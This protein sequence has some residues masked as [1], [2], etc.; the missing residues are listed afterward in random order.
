MWYTLNAKFQTKMHACNAVGCMLL[1]QNWGTKMAWP[2][3]F[4]PTYNRVRPLFEISYIPPLPLLS[5]VIRGG[6]R[7]AATSKMERFVIQFLILEVK[8]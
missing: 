7:T 3:I 2:P 5:D 8:V 4:A 1:V 6:S